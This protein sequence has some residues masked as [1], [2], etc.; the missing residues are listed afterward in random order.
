MAP[1]PSLTD[2]GNGDLVLTGGWK[3]QEARKVAG[4]AQE[5][6]APGFDASSW[7]DATV[8]GT[9]LTTLVDQG[10]YPEPTYG[11]DNMAIPESLNREDYW[12]RAEFTP[13]ADATG[14]TLTLTFNGVNYAADVWLNGKRLGEIRG[15]FR[16]G[17]F[18][19]TALVHA[20]EPNALVVR[21][22]PVPH[23]G[24]PHEESMKAGAGPNGGAMLFD[25]PTFFCTEGWDWIPGIRDRVTGLW[26]DVVL[27]VG[28]P[29]R[30]GD[31]QVVTDLPLPDVSTADVRVTAVLE[32]RS[33]EARKPVVRGEFEGVTFEKTVSLAPGEKAV[34][35]LHARRAAPAAR[36]ASRACGG[37]TAT[38]SPSSTT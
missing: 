12:Y 2:A 31:V 7:L 17:V 8:P 26:Q 25:G 11:L 20:A 10:V 33:A 13:P 5:L 6:S 21:V 23:P 1:K 35:T 16:R 28:G 36:R 15:A 18:D 4:T 30:I 19:V 32:N 34:V 14:R 24:I 3:L 38:A 9:V 37:R 27:H 29:V 22:S